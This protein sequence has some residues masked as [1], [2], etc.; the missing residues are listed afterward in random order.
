MRLLPAW[1]TGLLGPWWIARL[2]RSPES[3]A[4]AAECTG[5]AYTASRGS[6]PWDAVPH[7]FRQRRTVMPCE[8][9]PAGHSP[10]KVSLR[11]QAETRCSF[12]PSKTLR[13]ANR[14]L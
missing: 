1:G 14:P 2:Q 3:W 11:G 6:P 12:S 9:S 5:S 4:R 13:Q 7:I 8:P 10:P